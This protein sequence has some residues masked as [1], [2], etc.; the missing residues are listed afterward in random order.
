MAELVPVPHLPAT[1]TA[2]SSARWPVLRALAW[3][4]CLPIR[5]YRFAIGP[6]LPKVCRFHPSCSAALRNSEAL[7][8]VCSP[9]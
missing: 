2:H 8:R 1:S 6:A 5:F 3:L 9:Q 7:S 4:L